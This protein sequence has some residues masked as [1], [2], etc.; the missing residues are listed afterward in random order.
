MRK[1]RLTFDDSPTEHGQVDVELVSSPA[2][3]TQKTIL[4]TTVLFSCR[5]RGTEGKCEGNLWAKQNNLPCGSGICY[6]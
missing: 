1:S 2:L 3:L 6:R 4:L 5:G